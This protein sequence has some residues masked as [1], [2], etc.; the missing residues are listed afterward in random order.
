MRQEAGERDQ[1]LR[2]LAVFLE[3]LGLSPSTHMVAHNHAL[4][5]DKVGKIYKRC[6]VFLVG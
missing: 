3:N 6:R 4:S 1:W 2:S 5:L